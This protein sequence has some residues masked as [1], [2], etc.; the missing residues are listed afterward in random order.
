MRVERSGSL[1]SHGVVQ[2]GARPRWLVRSEGIFGSGS[3]FQE[4]RC[5]E[6][7]AWEGGS[8]GG[9]AAGVRAMEVC[10]GKVWEELEQRGEVAERLKA[11]YSPARRVM[12]YE[13]WCE[14]LWV[15]GFW[16]LRHMRPPTKWEVSRPAMSAPKGARQP[17]PLGPSPAR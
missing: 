15:Q 10:A 5:R 17:S 7:P 6:Y 14:S 4:R 9:G 11:I 3:G 2:E 12:E 8:A 13:W 16:V 1:G